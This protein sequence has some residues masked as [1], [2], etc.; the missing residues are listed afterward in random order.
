M[1]NVQLLSINIHSLSIVVC[2]FLVVILLVNYY[3]CVLCHFVCYYHMLSTM[4]PSLS[5]LFVTS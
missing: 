5:N 2:Y 3:L 1:S 4:V